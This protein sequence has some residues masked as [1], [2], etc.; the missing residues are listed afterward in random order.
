M[1]WLQ[2]ENKITKALPLIITLDNV[3]FNLIN[4]VPVVPILTLKSFLKEF[5]RHDE[6][7]LLIKKN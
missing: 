1:L 6:S 3:F 4:G 5:D 2:R 7:I